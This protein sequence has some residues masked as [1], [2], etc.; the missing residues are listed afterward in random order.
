MRK[1]LGLGAVIGALL[2]LAAWLAP[3]AYGDSIN[4]RHGIRRVLL[5]SVDG[6]H[7]LDYL[8]CTSGYPG[9]KRWQPVLPEPGGAGDQGRQLPGYF[10]LEPSDSFPGLMALMTGGSPR[11]M[12]VNYD[13]AYDRALYGP[14]DTTGNGLDGTGPNCT[15]TGT[16]TEYDEGIN[17]NTGVGGA[18]RINSF[19]T[20]ARRPATAGS[21]RSIRPAWYATRIA[22]RSIRG[23]LSASIRFSEL[24]MAREV[25]RPGPTS[26]RRIRR[27]AARLGPPPTRMSTTTTRRKSTPILRT[28]WSRGPGR[29]RG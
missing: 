10:D 21:T 12:G 8:N 11:T 1:K 3:R 18:R 23:T 6:F 28:I 29:F 17:L 15:T 5:I 20:A 13:V 16:T 27:W 24:S 7:A 14:M 4:N 19:S 2:L 9:R 26:I 25:T 22:I